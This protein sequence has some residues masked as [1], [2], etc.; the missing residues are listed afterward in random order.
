MATR[1]FLLFLFFMEKAQ[2]MEVPALLGTIQ[3][4]LYHNLLIPH[5]FIRAASNG[6]GEKLRYSALSTPSSFS[7][8][9]LYSPNCASLSSVTS[10]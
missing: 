5:F 3:K 10:G 1:V 4:T 2:E 8:I 9:F 6:R 7:R